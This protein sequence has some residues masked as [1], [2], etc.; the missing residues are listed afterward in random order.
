MKSARC[1]RHLNGLA[2]IEILQVSAGRLI[3][4]GSCAT[5]P[6]QHA[7]MLTFLHSYYLVTVIKMI[8]KC[9]A[10]IIGDMLRYD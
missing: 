8:E 2:S 5:A 10:C 6:S 7:K 3:A 9:N 4:Y 1:I